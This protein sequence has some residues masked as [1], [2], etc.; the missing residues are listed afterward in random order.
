MSVI[1]DKPT[2]MSNTMVSDYR[3][4]DF[5]E[6]LAV[7]NDA[8]AA[9]KGVIPADCW[10]E[11]YMSAVDLQGEIDSGVSFKVI[12]D[13][14]NYIV[15]VMGAQPVQDV[16]LIRHAYVRTATRRCGIGSKLIFDIQKGTTS[17][18][19]V[20]TWSA[21]TWAINFYKGHGFKVQDYVRTRDLLKKYWSVPERQAKQSVVLV[22]QS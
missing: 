8:A 1:N 16:L 6:V 18:I 14:E 17:S 22:H 9:Y 5:D 7:I 21:A 12:C 11:P 19:L 10:N 20:G 13:Q 15:G 2:T 3:A 4:E